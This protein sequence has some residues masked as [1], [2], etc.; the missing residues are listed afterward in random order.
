MKACKFIVASRRQ[1]IIMMSII[2]ITIVAKSRQGFAMQSFTMYMYVLRLDDCHVHTRHEFIHS[3][4]RW[5]AVNEFMARVHVA[6][7][8]AKHLTTRTTCNSLQPL[9]SFDSSNKHGH[10]SVHCHT[11]YST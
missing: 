10:M 5:S 6:I 2:L 8:H 4:P 9:W 11:T 3:A 1:P 7:V